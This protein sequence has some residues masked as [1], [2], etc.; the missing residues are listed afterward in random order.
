M[1]KYMEV[2]NTIYNTDIQEFRSGHTKFGI[3]MATYHRKNGKSPLY[4]KRSLTALMNQTATNWHLYLVGDKYEDNNELINTIDF[5]PKDKITFINLPIA[6]ERENITNKLDLWKVAGSNAYNHA[7][8]MAL[9]DN[10][11]YILHNDDDD[12]F[13]IK[14]IQCINYILSIY[15]DPSFIFHY[16]TYLTNHILPSKKI[17]YLSKNNLLP[18]QCNV[19]HTSFCLH[20]SIASEFKYDG[21]KPGKTT[22][23][24]GDVQ[25]IQYILNQLTNNTKNYTIFIP[26][27]LCNHDTDGEIRG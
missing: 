15:D 7:T 25:L 13:H 27:L 19:I 4:L 18:Q 3:C 17:N 9:K 10:C 24:C 23:E 12:P 22:Y 5:F 8:E 2:L 1:L 26:L 21:Y 11:D 14:K 20:K 6:P 16:S